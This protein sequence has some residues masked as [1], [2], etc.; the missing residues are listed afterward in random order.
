MAEQLV[1]VKENKD[2]DIPFTVKNKDGSAY[3]L[4]GHTVVFNISDKQYVHKF[5]GICTLVIAADGTCKY[6]VVAGDLNLPAGDYLG[7]LD[8]TTAAGLLL[9]NAA[10]TSIKIVEGC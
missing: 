6:S 4:T 2:F 7:D 1:L 8:L 9:T 3:D 5:N 10:K